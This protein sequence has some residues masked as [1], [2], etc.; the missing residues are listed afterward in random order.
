METEEKKIVVIGSGFGGLSSAIRLAHKGYDVTVYEKNKYPGGKAGVFSV[1]GFYFDLGPTLITM[2]EVIKELFYSVDEKPESYI[3]LKKLDI[4]CKYFFPDDSP[5]SFHSDESLLAKEIEEKTIDRY[6][7]LKRYFNY[8]KRIYDLTSDLFL[9]K[10]FSIRNNLF[11]KKSWKTLFH[12]KDIDPF[13][14]IDQANRSFFR[15]Y[16]LIRI[17]NRFATYGG[18][19]PYLAP[20]TLNIIPYIELKLGAHTLEKGIPELTTALYELA[21]RK[22][23]KFSFN[24]RVK[25][26]ITERNRVTGIEIKTESC[27]KKI[28]RTDT[29][30]NNGDVF[31][32]YSS[33]LDKGSK[34][35]EAELS[36]SAII[37]LW[38]IKKKNKELEPHNILF[39]ENYEEEFYELF[40]EKIIPNDPTIYI[41]ISSKINDSDAPEGCENWFV[42]INTPNLSGTTSFEEIDHI[43]ERIIEKIKNMT[44]I[45][46]G[47]EIVSERIITPK[48]IQRKTLCYQGAIYGLSGNSKNAAFLREKNRSGKIK[49]LYFAGGTAHPGGGIPLVLLSGKIVSDFFPEVSTK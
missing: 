3:K 20:A 43:R 18:S 37:F 25:R 41:Y 26:I 19:S 14:T 9:K 44:D 38:G 13:R 27:R 23:V 16:K 5:I 39:S 6:A 46:L 22:G 36:S 8:S 2:P 34:L 12:L 35:R 31:N 15:D 33:L 11:S 29:I 4:S 30:I 1:K 49:G 48:D 28:I 7:D 42:M 10:E 47:K 21:L 24:T 32:T 17:F 40:D 45:D